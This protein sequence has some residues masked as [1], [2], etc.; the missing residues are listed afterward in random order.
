MHYPLI[1]V[2]IPNY[3]HSKYLDQRIQ[4]VLN[5][6]YQNF[7]VII[8]DDCSP[9]EGSSR[10]VIEKYRENPHV[11][12]IIYNDENSG[13]PYKQWA[14]GANLAKG[15]LLWIAESDD[16]ADEHFLE[17]L[18]PEFHNLGTSVAFCRSILFNE[19]GI[20]GPVGPKNIQD[21]V[22]DGK[23]FIHDFMHSGT[24]IV[25]AS[26]ALFTKEAF[27]SISKDYASLKGAGDRLFWI[28]LAEKGDVA[29]VEKP[30]NYF[31]AHPNNTTKKCNTNGVN[32]KEDKL[33]FDYICQKGYIAEDEIPAIVR[34]YVRIHIF[35][36]ITDKKLQQEL[37][38]VWN[39][40]KYQQ[41]SL[42]L[43]AW[44]RKNHQ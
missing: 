13:S 36:M 10:S 33:I 11:S 3:C 44:M 41:L 38:R 30:Y 15:E 42:R 24:G 25:N 4:S 18:V 20:I 23:K 32:Q 39:F 31:R 14:K 9:D 22:M 21:G 2:I 35:E 8:L 12:H 7:E 5:Q 27:M 26:S 37:Y 43:N 40:N 1:S 28:L 29:F 19:K 17:V 6:T 34:E 16:Y